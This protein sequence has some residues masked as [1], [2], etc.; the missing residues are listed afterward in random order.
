MQNCAIAEAAP[1]AKGLN[2]NTTKPIVLITGGAGFLGSALV[3]ELLKAKQECGFSPRQIRILD[4]R[5]IPHLHDKRLLYIRGDIRSRAD[6]EKAC[7]GVD[8]IFHCAAVIDWG[9]RP[10]SFLHDVN[11]NGTRN[12]LAAA[13]NSGARAM[14]HTST[15][16]VV[17]DGGEI[18]NGDETIPYPQKFDMAYAETKA[19]SEKMVMEANGTR[20]DGGNESRTPALRTCVIRPCGMFGE[21]DPYHVSSFLRM[22]QSGRL[23]FRIGSGRALFQHVYVGNVA[24]AHVLAAKSLL[25]PNSPAAG[26]AYFVTDFQA[27]NFFDYMEPILRGIGYDMPPKNKTIPMPIMYA[28]GGLIEGIS[29]IAGP[30][31]RLK[32]VISRTSVNMVCKDLTFTGEKARRDLGYRPL[33]GEDEAIART[34]EYF[35]THGPCQ[36]F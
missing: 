23:T 10:R 2:I 20:R 29:W 18:I 17:Y 5:P 3:R 15:M 22:A 28:L 14:V 11:V 6:M 35:K 24:H 25:E 13:L 8:V 34:V 33:Y 27:K 4:T 16:D 1:V 30:F 9:H 26:N 19:L 31:I 21:G 12:V 36:P 7:A 32:P